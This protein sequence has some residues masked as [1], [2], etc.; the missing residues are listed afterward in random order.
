MPSAVGSL[1]HCTV[2]TNQPSRAHTSGE[3][4]G[5][6]RQRDIKRTTTSIAGCSQ[7]ALRQNAGGTNN[8]WWGKVPAPKG[9]GARIELTDRAGSTVLTWHRDGYLLRAACLCRPLPAW[10]CL[11]SLPACQAH[12]A[13]WIQPHTQKAKMSM[14]LRRY[15]ST[16]CTYVGFNGKLPDNSSRGFDR[17]IRG[18]WLA[19]LFA[20]HYR[21]TDWTLLT[22]LDL[23]GLDGLSVSARSVIPEALWQ[24][25]V[26][27]PGLGPDRPA[28]LL[29][30]TLPL[31]VNFNLGE[32]SIRKKKARVQRLQPRPPTRH[33]DQP[34]LRLPASSIHV[35]LGAVFSVCRHKPAD[36]ALFLFAAR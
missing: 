34:A 6:A 24:A 30:P 35:T 5:E 32:T 31:L 27:A 2:P 18:Q 25:L 19:A 28:F 17:G 22:L 4:D 9:N 23:P 20:I 13:I 21:P 7:C 26:N 33:A 1:N 29:L 14:A 12:G 36:M 15:K 10:V 3:N 16:K 8:K 11:L